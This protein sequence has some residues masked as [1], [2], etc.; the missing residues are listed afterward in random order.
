[1]N[2]YFI[3]SFCLKLFI[4]SEVLFLI[5][6][7][8]NYFWTPISCPGFRGQDFSGKKIIMIRAGYDALTISFNEI[9]SILTVKFKLLRV[10]CS[11]TTFDPSLYQPRLQPPSAPPPPNDDGQPPSDGLISEKAQASLNGRFFWINKK[12]KRGNEEKSLIQVIQDIPADGRKVR[13]IWTTTYNPNC[14]IYDER[15]ITDDCFNEANKMMDTLRGDFCDVFTF[16]AFQKILDNAEAVP[17]EDEVA[18]IDIACDPQAVRDR[19]PCISSFRNAACSSGASQRFWKVEEFLRTQENTADLNKE[20]SYILQV[21]KM[22]LQRAQRD[23]LD[24]ANFSGRLQNE[25]ECWAS[26]DKLKAALQKLGFDTTLVEH[27]LTLPK[28]ECFNICFEKFVKFIISDSTNT[29]A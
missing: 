16:T 11:E 17:E 5:L 20:S 25:M 1:M 2:N 12:R 22:E 28:T 19:T 4:K 18:A 14:S 21:L 9:N 10:V 27:A 3:F 26:K 8:S 29:L 6:Q 13:R 15:E 24:S 23:G 7:G